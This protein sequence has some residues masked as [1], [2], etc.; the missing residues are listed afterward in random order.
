MTQTAPRH[1]H[2]HRHPAAPP[3]ADLRRVV[4]Q[5]I[6]PGGDEVVELH[7]PDRPLPGER[8]ADA[9]AQDGAFR[10]RGVDQAIPELFEQR[11]QQQERIA[12]R[13]ADILAEHEDA[14][15][16]GQRVP[17]ARGDAFEK[18]GSAT[19]EGRPWIDLRQRRIPVDGSPPRRVEHLHAHPRRLVCGN[20]G[21]GEGRV[22]PIRGD[23]RHGLA[24]DQRSD[25]SLPL[26]KVAIADDAV[27]PQPFGV[28][29]DG[30]ARGPVGVGLTIRVPGIGGARVFPRRRR[31]PAEV[32]HV[33]V[34]GMPA[35]AHRHE[36][37][38]RRPEPRSR[39]LDRPSDGRRD[40]VGVGAVDRDAGNAVAGGLVSEHP[41]GR[42]L[43]HR[44]R[45][46]GLIVLEA[47][48][49]GKL[50]GRA[51]VD[52]LVPFAERRAAFADERNRHPARA[53][54]LKRQGHSGER[55]RADGEW[56]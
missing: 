52:R 6:E 48:D 43:A 5:L 13:A 11:P 30:I 4:H 21:A 12:I 25:L 1:A 32:E 41:H 56:C 33:V 45:Q 42:L 34:M 3:V 54:A 35:H 23:H 36:L 20:A 9:D 31:I 15:I 37:N 53:V 39:P 29:A 38:Q 14:G 47:E 16:G 50:A 26:V 28:S 44:R 10:E 27:S 19:V 7:L 22:G 2:D 8:R 18:G 40:L 46:R 49:R 17:D 55:Q 24:L 51:Q